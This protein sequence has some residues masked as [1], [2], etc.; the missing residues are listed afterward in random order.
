M[1]PLARSPVQPNGA[2]VS[3]EAEPL[4]PATVAGLQARCTELVG[5][6]ENYRDAYLLCYVRGPEGIIVELVER[7]ADASVRP[8][9]P[10]KLNR[11]ELLVILKTDIIS[12]LGD[13]Q[14][15]SGLA[16]V[17]LGGDDRGHIYSLSD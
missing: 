11:W 3:A 1:G 13:L 4:R 6:V 10:S 12:W 15:R 14:R 7:P 8:R 17:Y 2:Q 16:L 5:E 9:G